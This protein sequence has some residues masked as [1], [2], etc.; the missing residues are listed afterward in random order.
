MHLVESNSATPPYALGKRNPDLP[1][2]PFA[3]T[4]LNNCNRTPSFHRLK[5]FLPGKIAQ[6][7]LYR[8]AGPSGKVAQLSEA[9]VHAQWMVPRD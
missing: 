7:R 4:S 1:T 6:S 9:L 3:D 8:R 5:T 2:S